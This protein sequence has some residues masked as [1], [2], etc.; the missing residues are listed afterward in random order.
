MFEWCS[1]G[2]MCTTLSIPLLCV[3]L[4][5]SS[6]RLDG[7]KLRN[8]RALVLLRTKSP[9]G[10][11]CSNFTIAESELV[12]AQINLIMLVSPMMTLK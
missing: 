12:A 7:T 9:W 11:F 8:L 3:C 1:E 10:P 2:P 4:V 5:I 6:T